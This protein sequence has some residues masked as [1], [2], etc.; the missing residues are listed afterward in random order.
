MHAA[1]RT[2]HTGGWRHNEM[3]EGDNQDDQTAERETG[4]E[5]NDANK[6]I[7][8]AKI[9]KTGQEKLTVTR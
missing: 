2:G 7:F 5:N 9:T 1:G 4:R 6:D 8:P 3:N